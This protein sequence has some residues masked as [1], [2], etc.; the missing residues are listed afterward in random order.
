MHYYNIPACMHMHC[1]KINTKAM[2]YSVLYIFCIYVAAGVSVSSKAKLVEG[3]V[4][5][6]Q[7]EDSELYKLHI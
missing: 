4:V 6:R 3:A 5:I 1:S 7:I 2:L